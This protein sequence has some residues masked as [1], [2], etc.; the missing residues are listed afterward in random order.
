L[1]ASRVFS[2]AAGFSAPGGAGV[3]QT[4]RFRRGIACAALSH[5]PLLVLLILLGIAVPA[6]G[7]ATAS[8]AQPPAQ[9]WRPNVINLTRVES[10][11]FFDPPETG[12]DPDYTFIANRVR[13]GLSGA[14][15]RVQINGAIQYVQFGGLPTAAT[16]PGF[17]GTGSLYYFHSSSTTSHGVYVPALNVRFSLPS[18]ITLLAG[19]FGYTSGAEAPSGNARIEAIKRSRVDSRLVGDFEWSLYQRAFDG[20]RADLDRRRWHLSA[21]YLR[22]TQGGFEE[23]AGKSLGP[24]DLGAFTMTWRPD[25]LVPAT[26]VAAFSYIYSDD[27]FVTTRPDNTGLAAPRARVSVAAFGA[28]A[29]GSARPG[30]V[31]LDWLGWY[32][33]QT[34]SWYG[35]DHAAFSLAIEGGVQWRTGW[36][37]WVRGGYL[38]A[39]GDDDPGD[40]RHGTYFAMVPTVRRY[41]YTTIYAPMNLR[42]AFVEVVLRPSARVRGRADVRR[43]W[44]AEG[45]DRWYA[46]SGATQSAG[47]FFGYAG[48]NS[49][50]H[51]DFGTVI[52]GA[53]DVS[54]GRRLSINGFF[55]A[56]NGGDVVS[57]LFRGSWARFGYFESVIQF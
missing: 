2:R 3:S 24:V 14:W 22:P 7:Q 54:V 57:T 8:V 4:G 27:R 31:D 20:A 43:L 18:G 34:G 45:A 32:A 15:K 33:Q 12:G 38:H 52:E 48:R 47:S 21:A 46:G 35:Q 40:D 44:L 6:S 23:S 50:G 10:W 49:G 16:G 9:A 55:G 1:N 13:I 42:D 25:A 36:Q 11:S 53:L 28:S 51:T 5:V 19:R 17:L 39:S 56:M 29:I 37:P 41:S 26:D 30:R